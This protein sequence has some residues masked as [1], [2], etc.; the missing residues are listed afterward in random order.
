[1]VQLDEQRPIKVLHYSF[2][3]PDQATVEQNPQFLQG[4]RVPDNGGLYFANSDAQRCSVVVPAKM[5]ALT[6]LGP[7]NILIW[8]QRTE[9]DIAQLVAGFEVWSMARLPGDPFTRRRREHVLQRLKNKIVELLCGGDWAASERNMA[10]D[11]SLPSVLLGRLSLDPRCKPLSTLLRTASDELGRLSVAAAAELLSRGLR[12]Y[13][14]SPAISLAHDHG[15]GSQ[16]WA[17]EFALRVFIETERV[18]SWAGDEFFTVLSY[19]L[20]NPIVGRVAR[21]VSLSHDLTNITIGG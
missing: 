10:D 13:A 5:H 1:V 15:I 4:Y 7:G 12:S 16:Q 2:D 8:R 19:L 9:S 6:D 17:T 14:E 18:R 21:I 20:R 11:P 3:A